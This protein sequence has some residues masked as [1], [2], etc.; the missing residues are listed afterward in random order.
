MKAQPGDRIVL[1]PVSI[2]GPVRDGE[3]LETRGPGGHAPYLVRW[4]DGHTGLLY[5]GPG[6]VLR[7]NHATP[8][9]GPADTGHSEPAASAGGTRRVHDWQV[10]V[11]IFSSD[12][13]TE[14]HVVLLADSP[15]HL[16]ARGHSHRGASDRP[17]PEIGDEVAVAR[18]L[19]RLAD[20]LLDTA[21][22]DIE[23][24]TGE[25]DVTLRSQ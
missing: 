12:D 23:G 22:T 19:R 18:A 24:V 13:D 21:A 3:V 2:E 5:P 6:S 17:V 11:T 10:R 7:V 25:H 9:A 16:S 4:S 14:A 20:Q 15:T 8:E 1:A